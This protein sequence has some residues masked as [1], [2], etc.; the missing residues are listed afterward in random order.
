VGTVL[1]LIRSAA[2]LVWSAFLP[3]SVVDP[4]LE[5]ELRDVRQASSD[6]NLP[7][8]WVELDHVLETVRARQVDRSRPCDAISHLYGHYGL[9]RLS[10][11][12]HDVPWVKA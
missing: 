10:R 9:V 2:G 3:R 12:G 11:L 8:S 7:G 4:L 6:A 1:P 5:R